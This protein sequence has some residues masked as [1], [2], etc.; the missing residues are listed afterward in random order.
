[1]T[2]SKEVSLPVNF[3]TVEHLQDVDGVRA[4]V[5]HDGVSKEQSTSSEVGRD[6]IDICVDLARRFR[7][8]VTAP[9]SGELCRCREKTTASNLDEIW[10]LNIKCFT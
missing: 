1:M 3:G 10:R 8:A 9:S 4:G 2:P 7:R 5:L 6:K